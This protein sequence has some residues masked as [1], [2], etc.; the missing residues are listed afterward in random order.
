MDKQSADLLTRLGIT[1]A[2]R[3]HMI[4]AVERVISRLTD[5]QVM[6]ETNSTITEA[7]MSNM[8]YLLPETL[9]NEPPCVKIV[10][11][12]PIH[13]VGDLRGHFVHLM[14][15]LNT[16]GHPPYA[17]YVF[18]GNYADQG[19]KSLD[20]LGILFAY[21]LLYPNS[22]YLLRGKH[23]SDLVSRSYGLYGLLFE[24]V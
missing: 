3:K 13:V 1:N 20:T 23:E 15:M 11:D 24:E 19:A 17:R 16:I 5:P 22:L 7:E 12:R 9:L 4:R 8:C 6:K 21:K 14:H 18:L 10:L 2:M